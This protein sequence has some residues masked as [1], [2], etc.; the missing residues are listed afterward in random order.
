[1][2]FKPEFQLYNKTALKQATRKK[3]L[4]QLPEKLQQ[5]AAGV[6]I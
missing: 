4:L 5:T 2:Y 6:L 1:M 3:I